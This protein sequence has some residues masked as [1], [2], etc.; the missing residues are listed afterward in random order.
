MTE[1]CLSK[2]LDLHSVSLHC[3]LL[4]VCINPLPVT[5]TKPVRDHLQWIG[6]FGLL[7]SVPW[8]ED[9]VIQWHSGSEL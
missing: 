1:R 7:V 9:D 8:E 4:N 2:F 5:V 6:L 3:V